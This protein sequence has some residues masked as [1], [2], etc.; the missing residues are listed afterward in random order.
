MPVAV[1]RP[2]RGVGGAEP[3]LDWPPEAKIRKLYEAH[4]GNVAAVARELR[5]KYQA[6]YWKLRDLGLHRSRRRLT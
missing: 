5:F 2:R 1:L 4:A 3:Q 6:V